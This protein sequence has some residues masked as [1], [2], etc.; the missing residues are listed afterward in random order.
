MATDFWSAGNAD[1]KQAAYEMHGPLETKF[2][3]GLGIEALYYNPEVRGF[4]SR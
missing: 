4:D 1:P 3:T 2:S